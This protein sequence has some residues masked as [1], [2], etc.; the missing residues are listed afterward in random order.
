[1]PPVRIRLLGGL[2]VALPSG[3]SFTVTSRKAKALLAYLAATPGAVH[4]RAKVAALLWEDSPEERARTSLRQA[5]RALRAAFGPISETLIIAD[6]DSLRLAPQGV[7]VDVAAFEALLD[8]GAPDAFERALDLY[9]GGFLEALDPKAPAFEFWM[10]A[11]RQRLHDRAVGAA[12][13]L[14][15]HQ[16]R[17]GLD[18]QALHTALRLLALDPLQEAA[19]RTV[20]EVYAARGR[21]ADAL[22]QYR[23]CRR[24]L[25]RELGVAPEPETERLHRAILAARRDRPRREHG[26]EA[27]EGDAANGIGVALPEVRLFPELRPVT[28]LFAALAGPHAAEDVPDGEA[29]DPE[30]VDQR[31]RDGFA[32]IERTVTAYGGTAYE[33]AQGTVMAVFGIPTAHGNDTE[34]AVRA[35]FDVQA[36][37]ADGSAWLPGSFGVGIGVACGSVLVSQPAPRDFGTPRLTGEAVSRAASLAARAAPGTVLVSDAVRAVLHDRMDAEPA[38][39]AGAWRVRAFRGPDDGGRAPLVGR[40]RERR[41]LAGIAETCLETGAGHIVCIRG[42]AGIGK[43]RLI[44]DFIDTARRRGFACHKALVLD[45]GT[46][47]GG[48]ALRALVRSLLDL[49]PGGTGG[50]EQAAAERAMWA[51]LIDS[52]QRVFLYDLLGLEQPPETRSVYDAMDGETRTR[53]RQGVFVRLIEAL[54]ARRPRLLVIEDVHWADAQ[55]L[56]CLARVASALLDHPAV[57]AVTA[58]VEGDPLDAVWRGAKGRTPMTTIDL[59][60]LT[61]REALDL[62]VHLGGG[63]DEFIRG[64]V[65]RAEG[66]PL[67]LEQLVRSAAH[68]EDDIP[69]TIQSL[70]LA[71][72]DDLPPRDRQAVQAAA[73]LGQRFDLPALR[74]LLEDPAYACTSL[75]EQ[76]LVRPQGVNYLFAHALIRDAVYASLPRSRRRALHRRA[77]A[78]FAGVEP[79]LQ[80]EHLERGDDP[81][82]P[83]AYRRAAR[84]ALA[85]YRYERAL[86]LAERGLALVDERADRFDLL[87]VRGE[88]L[89]SLGRIGESI[90]AFR[91]ALELADS[92]PREGQAWLG[93]A[94]GMRVVDRYAEALDALDRAERA[95]GDADHAED[96]AHIHFLRGNILFPLGDVERCLGEHEKALHVAR[97]A[98]SRLREAQALGGLGDAFY[99]RGRMVTANRTYRRCVRLARRYGFGRVEVAN[100]YMV[101]NTRLYRNELDGALDDALAGIRL[102]SRTGHLRAE[103]LG[104]IITSEVFHEMAAPDRMQ[105]HLARGHALVHQLGARRFEPLLLIM[106]AK[107]RVLLGRPEEAL[108]MLERAVSISQDTGPTFAGPWALG[109]LALVTSDPAR[110]DDA[111]KRGERIL[112]GGAVSHNYLWFYRDAMEVALRR[113]DGKGAERFAAALE[114]YTRAEPLPW[115]DVYVRRAKALIAFGYFPDAPDVR[116]ELG[117]VRDVCTRARLYLARMAVDAALDR[118]RT[119]QTVK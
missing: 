38:G 63:D 98:G 37:F 60:P 67:F 61:D 80:A 31:L 71:R 20:M 88:V 43:T 108:P 81:G 59:G 1:M 115:S 3:Q 79:A 105:D 42:E 84:A 58:R 30:T 90:A 34:R 86:A 52:D 109:A 16:R 64:C 99:M 53:G 25:A 40:H 26:V 7:A 87:C 117:R 95:L 48:D 70:V 97:R 101:A 68:R 39:G 76:V 36:T 85:D 114:A 19:H 73:V 93:T 32:S 74:H 83:S 100:L 28:I 18:D 75:V 77:A 21:P 72:L 50:D 113:G 14:M 4:P 44:E 92:R 29:A 102:A 5:L 51:G 69:V 119:D 57:L 9:R 12:R 27:T 82:A 111:L 55:T 10:T 104:H 96:R 17:S 91:E 2:H 118:E 41:Q 8:E 66:N 46:D 47:A 78:W 15:A 56:A 116:R 13:D 33:Q 62:A 45:F 110:A 112:A 103:L 94:A 23:Q 24:I 65:E 89:R 49:S 11:E 22:K 6:A 35:A 54:N 106:D 107:R